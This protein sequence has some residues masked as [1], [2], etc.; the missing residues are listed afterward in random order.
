MSEISFRECEV[1]VCGRTERV[2]SV[3]KN[4]EPVLA[5]KRWIVPDKN[6][7]LAIKLREDYTFFERLCQ[8]ATYH[9]EGG[10]MYGAISS[11]V[12]SW[13]IRNFIFFGFVHRNSIVAQ[14][15]ERH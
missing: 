11:V 3:I 1:I 14:N 13:L 9:E 8:V 10:R 15:F 12:S 7:S 4:G 2:I 5:W 6:F